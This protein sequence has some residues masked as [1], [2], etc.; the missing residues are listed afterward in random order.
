MGF[1]Q[2]LED[3]GIHI[4]DYSGKIDLAEGLSR[5]EQLEKQFNLHISDGVQLK[6]LFDVRNT[7]WESLQTHDALAKIARQKF[8]TAPKNI[9]R[10]TAILNNQYSGPTFENEH[11]FTSKDEALDWLLQDHH[12]DGANPYC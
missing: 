4:I 2:F 3:D 8:A 6:V 12:S 11:W 1:Y 7:I 9:H 10:Y 5:M